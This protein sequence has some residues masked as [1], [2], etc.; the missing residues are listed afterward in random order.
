M[1]AACEWNDTL[2]ARLRALWDE[3]LS[4]AEIG[5]RLGFSKNAVIGK[6]HRL[7]LSPRR[8]PI[9]AAGS[10]KPRERHR[11][12]VPK[13][14][15]IAPL[16]AVPTK[17]TTPPQPAPPQPM[18]STTIVSEPVRLG[19]TLCCWP[20]GA[21]GTPD[22]RFCNERVVAGKPYCEAHCA[23]AYV[24]RVEGTNEAA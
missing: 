2:I 18:P 9:R 1:H 11:P 19:T 23:R 20:I 5:R 12:R 16:R 10:G 21:P 22:F 7:D 3:G 17:P 4:T 6:A 13:L 14:A 24:K 15:D 8:S